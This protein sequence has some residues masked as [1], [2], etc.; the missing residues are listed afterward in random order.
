MCCLFARSAARKYKKRAVCGMQ[1][2][3]G[4]GGNSVPV[5]DTA[6]KMRF[7]RPCPKRSKTVKRILRM[8]AEELPDQSGET[9][10]KNG[11]YIVQAD[12]M[13]LPNA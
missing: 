10:A 7:L 8:H 1:K 5:S 9:V 6:E 13:D 3:D 2:K 11:F 12:N 4:K